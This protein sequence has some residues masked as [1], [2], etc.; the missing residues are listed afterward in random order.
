MS[1]FRL[2]FVNGGMRDCFKIES[3]DDILELSISTSRGLFTETYDKRFYSV[4]LNGVITTWYEWI[5]RK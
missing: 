4:D 5:V 1:Y 2:G 3:N